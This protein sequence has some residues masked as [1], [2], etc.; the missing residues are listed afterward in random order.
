MQFVEAPECGLASE[1]VV[2]FYGENDRVLVENVADFLASGSHK[3]EETVVIAGPARTNA[4]LAALKIRAVG[5]PHG[6][7]RVTALDAES[8]LDELL[9]DGFPDDRRFDDAVGTVVRRLRKHSGGFGV[10]AYGEMVG[11]LWQRRQYP[12]AIRLEQLWNSLLGTRGIR[13]FCAYP[14]DVFSADFDASV[15]SALLCAHGTL[16][17]SDSSDALETAL[18]RALREALGEDSPLFHTLPALVPEPCPDLPVAE[19]T[20][21]RLRAAMPRDAEH[22]LTRAKEY[23]AGAQ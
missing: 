18:V 13:L 9:V 15:V 19:A 7:A 12:A 21:L 23:Y 6:D 10:G 16:L 1:H 2:Q 20:I 4:I 22:I 5:A 3:G 11:L 17:S 14:I 8:V